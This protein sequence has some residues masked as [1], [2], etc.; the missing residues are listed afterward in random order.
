[1]I[2]EADYWSISFEGL[3]HQPKIMVSS[4]HYNQLG[5]LM[6]KLTYADSINGGYNPFIQKIDY[7]Y[8]IRGWLTSINNPDS[9]NSE[10]DIFS[11]NL[12][13]ENTLNGVTYKPQ[14]NGNISS[15][16]WKTNLNN[17]K[18][19]YGLIYDDVNR[20]DTAN[21]FQN[22]GGW[23]HDKSFDENNISYDANGN[24]LTLD[25][26]ATSG[27]K[28]DQLTYNYFTNSNQIAFIKDMMGDV[29]GAN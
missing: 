28:I 14:Y 7:N 20:L 3:P 4:M 19:A 8:N 23:T 9:V 11:L 18:Y 21:F 1:M 24:I 12:L 16:E 5:Q 10:N 6:N 29:P 17:N 26:Y 2:T 25:R 22:N 15:M 13:Y 27:Q